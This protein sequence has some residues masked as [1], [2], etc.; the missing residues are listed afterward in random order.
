MAFE[1][2]QDRP[3]RGGRKT[4]EASPSAG[5]ITGKDQRKMLEDEKERANLKTLGA[6]QSRKVAIDIMWKMRV[7]SCNRQSCSTRKKYLRRGFDKGSLP[8]MKHTQ[9]DRRWPVAGHEASIEEK[10]GG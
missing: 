9:T 2:M 4:R 8:T 5:P 1:T 7:D 3:T 6:G 10:E